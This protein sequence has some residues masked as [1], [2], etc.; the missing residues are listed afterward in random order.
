MDGKNVLHP[1]KKYLENKSLWDSQ[2]VKGTYFMREM[3]KILSTQSETYYNWFWKKDDKSKKAYEKIG[4]FKKFEPLGVFLGSGEYI[5]DFEQNLKQRILKNISTH[6]Y[7]ENDY[8]FVIDYEGIYLAYYN[9]EFIGKT[10][11]EKSFN[12]N[13]RSTFETMKKVSSEGGFISYYHTTKPN[14]SK[15]SDKN[16]HKYSYIDNIKDWGWIIGTGFYMD[17]FYKSLEEKKEELNRTHNS[18]IQ[19]IL[20]I[21]FLLTLFILM[22]FVKVSNLLEDKFIKHQKDIRKQ[23]NENIKKR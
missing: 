19:K 8:V 5:N 2:D 15:M 12:P 16:I 18:S 10:V 21:S 6:T 23:I 17:D 22:I 13:I 7:K 3:N 9:S 1:Q 14:E 11:Y 20:V 4:F